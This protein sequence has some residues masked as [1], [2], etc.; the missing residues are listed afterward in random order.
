MWVLWSLAGESFP[1]IK[2][3]DDHV[4][5]GMESAEVTKRCLEAH[6]NTPVFVAT[7][8]PVLRCQIPQPDNMWSM[9]D[10][11][12][13]WLELPEK[14]ASPAEF[15]FDVCV[16]GGDWSPSS[17]KLITHCAI[18]QS[19]NQY[20]AARG[21]LFSHCDEDYSGSWKCHTW[22]GWTFGTYMVYHLKWKQRNCPQLALLLS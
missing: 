9:T 22:C 4:S 13:V 3:A 10:K 8:Q 15:R 6:V 16:I 17:S 2:A 5:S 7:D 20:V 12:L 11:E 19:V 14:T 1:V 21:C 18:S